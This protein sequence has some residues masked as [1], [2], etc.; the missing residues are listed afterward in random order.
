[1]ENHETMSRSKQ[2]TSFL[3]QQLDQT[4]TFALGETIKLESQLENGRREKIEL[5]ANL[6]GS[7]EVLVELRKWDLTSYR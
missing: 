1:M 3:L 4:K 2:E 5:E 7:K 6:W